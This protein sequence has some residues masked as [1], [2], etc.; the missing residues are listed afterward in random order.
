MSHFGLVM[1]PSKSDSNSD[2]ESAKFDAGYSGL[3]FTSK[4][5][6]KTELTMLPRVHLERLLNLCIVS[7][8]DLL[9]DADHS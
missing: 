6:S 2:R 5:V 3:S 1:F 9:K 4:N 8:V 7:E